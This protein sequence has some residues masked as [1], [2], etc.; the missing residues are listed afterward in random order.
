[1]VGCNLDSLKA[2]DNDILKEVVREGERRIDA[3]LATANAADQRAMAWAALL[4][5]V[6]A[7][8]LGGSAALL[9]TGKNL[10][11]AGTGVGVAFM[12]GVAIMK[13]IDVV[14]PKNFDFPGNQ[15]R[16]WLPEKWQ[17][18]GTGQACDLRQAL[19][20]QAATL[21]EQIADNAAAADASGLQLRASMDL[22][23]YA[24]VLGAIVVGALIVAAGSEALLT[25]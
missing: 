2:L 21:D 14:R 16:N 8:V 1:M 19:L 23:L 11:L 10:L 22:A 7:A 3:Q 5:T 25:S 9:T 15:P 17:C 24:V 6:A 20:E 12:L 18:Y 4:V 13:A